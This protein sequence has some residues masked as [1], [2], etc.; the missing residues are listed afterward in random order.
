MHQHQYTENYTSAPPAY[1]DAN[2]SFTSP[3]SSSDQNHTTT[4]NY[5][6][7][8]A[9]KVIITKLPLSIADSELQ[10]LLQARVLANRRSRLDCPIQS[11]EVQRGADG[12]SRGHAFVVFDSDMLARKCI[13]ELRGMEYKGRK[14]DVRLAKEGVEPVGGFGNVGSTTTA[15]GN[16]GY[17]AEQSGAQYYAGGGGGGG[18]L[19]KSGGQ[20]GKKHGHGHGHGE[21]NAAKK[22]EKSSS[23][24][25]EKEKEKERISEKQV[26]ERER[27]EEKENRQPCVVNGSGSRRTTR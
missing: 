22:G 6:Q 16:N 27:K 7:P 20:S 14:L 26:Q 10:T 19:V 1:S 21:K 2:T 13:A 17:Y 5:V 24:K 15:E 18:N 23:E 12:K 4:T 25:K 3:I 8:E 9:R 11:I